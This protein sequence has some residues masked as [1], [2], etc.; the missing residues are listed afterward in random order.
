MVIY[1]VNDTMKLVE[2]GAVGKIVC[3]ED[4]PYIRIKLKNTETGEFSAVYVK[5]DQ[6]NNPDIY[7]DKETGVA[8]DK[9]E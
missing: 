6:A 8:L 3:Y 1:G 7:K 2:S 5:A 9:I 4:L